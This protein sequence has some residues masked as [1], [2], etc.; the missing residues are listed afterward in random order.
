M[1]RTKK[2]GEKNEILKLIVLSMMAVGLLFSFAF[3]G[4]AA[5]GK[6]LFNDAKLS[7]ATAGKSCNSCHADGKGLDAFKKEFMGG[8]AKSIE[9]AT[10]MCITMMM[11]GK[12]LD[13][14]S[15]D[16]ANIVAY[17]KSVKGK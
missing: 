11:K 7:G 4:D 6:A 12:A 10:N 3:A 16:M 15:A 13:A 8:K 9:D 14:K 1:L 2:G 17:I 5:K